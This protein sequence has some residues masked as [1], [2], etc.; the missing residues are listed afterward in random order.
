[1]TECYLFRLFACSTFSHVK[2]I[3]EK[4][5]GKFSTAVYAGNIIITMAL[6]C[7]GI[8]KLTRAKREENIVAF[9]PVQASP[10]EY[11]VLLKK[12]DSITNLLMD[13]G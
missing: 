13:N 11:Y 1:M 4:D 6:F 7:F 8:R 12:Y 5:N 2:F 3:F 10:E 9:L